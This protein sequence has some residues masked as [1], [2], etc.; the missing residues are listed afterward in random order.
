M[1]VE[2]LRACLCTHVLMHEYKCFCNLESLNSL[3]LR[4]V[5]INVSYG[6]KMSHPMSVLTDG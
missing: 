2:Y 5:I 1:V 6:F 4:H 3:A